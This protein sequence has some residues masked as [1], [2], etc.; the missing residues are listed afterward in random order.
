MSARNYAFTSDVRWKTRYYEIVP[1]LDD[2]IKEAIVK[3]ELEK[4]HQEETEDVTG[5]FESV[6]A[7]NIALVKMEE[8]SIA[9]VDE[10]KSDEAIIILESNE[11]WE[12]K[13]IYQDGLI[14]YVETRGKQYD[15]TLEATTKKLE[16]TTE[17]TK[18]LIILNKN[19]IM[20]ITILAL[21]LSI[22][23]GFFIS[24]KITKPLSK[25]TDAVDEV[26][27]GNF[28]LKIKNDS[29]IDEINNLTD[30]LRRTTDS[31]KVSKWS[32]NIIEKAQSDRLKKKIKYQKKD[33]TSEFFKKESE[34]FRK[35]AK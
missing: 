15:E 2:T 24:R 4:E 20:G 12:Q 34:A 6:D 27:R 23:I 7:A 26:S 8:E 16:L 33:K 32:Q 21:I 10:G 19:S 3:G 14:N 13:R 9:L 1:K 28:K 29:N 11:Y 22:I 25:L 30:S 5:F 35:G 31:M 18:N 17:K